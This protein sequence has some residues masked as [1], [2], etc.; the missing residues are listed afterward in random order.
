VINAMA[1]LGRVFRAAHTRNVAL[2]TFAL[3][4]PSFFR[5]PSPN[6]DL[7]M[8]TTTHSSPR[9]TSSAVPH[10]PTGIE[11]IV[12]ADV[13]R[14]QAVGIAKYGVTVAE[15]PLSLR[16]WLQHAYEETLDKAVYLRRA[17]AEIDAQ[18]SP[19]SAHGK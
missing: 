19:P 17:I 15:N 18:S 14:R 4:A 5:L 1:S 2:P 3:G 6:Y 9:S 11:A 16:E 13:S 10:S 12:C 7:P 8:P